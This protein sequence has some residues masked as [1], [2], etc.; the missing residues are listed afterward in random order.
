MYIYIYTNM[1]IYIYT[2]YYFY[3]ALLIYLRYTEKKLNLCCNVYFHS[4]SLFDKTQQQS[5]KTYIFIFLFLFLFCELSNY[6]LL[7]FI[8][9]FYT[10]IRIFLKHCGLKKKNTDVSP[11]RFFFHFYR[12]YLLLYF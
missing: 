4:E 7:Y 11:N 10:Y 8:F 6:I 3:I 5:V 12:F 1:Y 2:V 9:Y